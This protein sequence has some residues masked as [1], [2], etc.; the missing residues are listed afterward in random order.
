MKISDKTSWFSRTVTLVVAATCIVAITAC[1][2]TGSFFKQAASP[3]PIESIGSAGGKIAST[4]AFETPDRLYV[5]GSMKK[6]LGNHIPPAA[7]VDIRLVD[8][9]GRVVAEKQ[10]DI[11]PGH[12]R[13]SSGRTGRYSY[14]ASFPL[15]E[16]RQAAKI[17]VQYHLVGHSS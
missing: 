9:S 14:V 12:P 11:D 5:S 4:R 3:L 10:D 2:S 13:L 7:H 6:G 8:S 16:A 1:A 17:I 15:P